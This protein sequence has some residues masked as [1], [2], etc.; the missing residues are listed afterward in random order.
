MPENNIP[1][2]DDEFWSR[3]LSDDDGGDERPEGGVRVPARP[4]PGTGAPAMAL[5]LPC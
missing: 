3:L 4:R 5:A 2:P 1:T